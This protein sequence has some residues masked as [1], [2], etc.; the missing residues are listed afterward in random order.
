MNMDQ[1][2]TRTG[3]CRQAGTFLLFAAIGAGAALGLGALTAGGEAHASHG[4]HMAPPAPGS[5]SAPAGEGVLI[6]LA[7]AK[8]PV[9]GGD[10]DGKSFTEWNGLRIGHCCPGCTKALLA[11][12]ERVLDE[13]GIDWRTAAAAAKRLADAPLAEREGVLLEIGRTFQVVSR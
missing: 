11:D 6:D 2:A 10:V 9:M 1:E 4:T 5:A 13:A 8:C 12:P 3:W 7:N